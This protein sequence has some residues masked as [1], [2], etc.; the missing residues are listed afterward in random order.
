MGLFC[1][2]ALQRKDV[3]IVSDEEMLLLSPNNSL[4]L[5]GVRND[6]G[7]TRIYDCR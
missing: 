3:K 1:Q 7:A 2:I 5:S 6:V 4:R